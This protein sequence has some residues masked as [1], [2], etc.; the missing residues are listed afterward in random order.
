MNERLVCEFYWW[1]I[2]SYLYPLH[3]EIFTI[4][5]LLIGYYISYICVST[6]LMHSDQI[7]S[8]V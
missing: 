1:C 7:Q 6:L 8:V 4:L 2:W 3:S 5:L